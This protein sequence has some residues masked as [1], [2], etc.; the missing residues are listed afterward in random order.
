MGEGRERVVENTNSLHTG[1][2]TPNLVGAFLPSPPL[3]TPFLPDGRRGEV[4][5]RGP[6]A[7]ERGWVGE[8]RGAGRPW[9]LAAFL[10]RRDRQGGAPPLRPR[11]LGRPASGSP[12]LGP[13]TRRVG[14]GLRGVGGRRLAAGARRRRPLSGAPSRPLPLPPADNGVP[15]PPP[16]PAPGLKARGPQPTPT[17][18]PTHGY[19]SSSVPRRC[20][21]RRPNEPHG[22]CRVPRRAP[23]SRTAYGR[24][25]RRSSATAELQ[26]PTDAGSHKQ[27]SDLANSVRRA[28]VT[29]IGSQ[30]P[31]TRTGGVGGRS[32]K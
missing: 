1:V 25:R 12:A 26:R 5:S 22:G 4:P 9:R 21:R 23:S 18:R 20:R 31:P 7:R 2:H 17:A 27:T 16:A 8:R 28:G 13:R 14:G 19:P 32:R 24:A 30:T 3:P 29:V 15:A 6:Q 10:P 11:R